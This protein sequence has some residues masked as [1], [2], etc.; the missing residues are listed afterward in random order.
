[1]KAKIFLLVFGAVVVLFFLAGWIG[2]NDFMND[3]RVKV[4]LTWFGLMGALATFYDPLKNEGANSVKRPIKYGVVGGVSAILLIA[5]MGIALPPKRFD[6]FTT[7]IPQLLGLVA[8]WVYVMDKFR[9]PVQAAAETQQQSSAAAEQVAADQPAQVGSSGE[10]AP[11][12]K[13]EPQVPK[14]KE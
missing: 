2:G 3:M 1:M 4:V 12:T 8:L 14:T 10:V 7:F 6:E 5:F 9:K 11:A 13:S